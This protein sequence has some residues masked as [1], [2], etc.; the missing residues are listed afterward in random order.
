[1]GGDERVL[2]S[3]DFVWMPYGVF[4][5]F[6]LMWWLRL[7]GVFDFVEVG[8]ERKWHQDNDGW[9][10]GRWLARFVDAFLIKREWVER[11]GAIPIIGRI[12]I[13]LIIFFSLPYWFQYVSCVPYATN[14]IAT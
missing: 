2:E 1:M 13:T 7:K 8:W 3:G 9:F 12:A 4:V 11:W 6:G 10:S 5:V 14:Y